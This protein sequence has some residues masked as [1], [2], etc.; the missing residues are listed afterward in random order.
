M[1][2]SANEA[3]YQEL[4]DHI[5]LL[6]KRG[7]EGKLTPM[8]AEDLEDYYE[9]LLQMRVIQNNTLTETL[10]EEQAK[11]KGYEN[12]MERT[13]TYFYVLV[14]LLLISFLY[15][16]AMKWPKIVFPLFTALIGFGCYPPVLVFITLI[17]SRN[18][19]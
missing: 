13:K 5:K 11:V 17:V 12:V 16:C 6:G 4:G 18:I 10:K 1:E 2:N 8:Q 7:K 9:R 19:R 15:F 3:N 14:L